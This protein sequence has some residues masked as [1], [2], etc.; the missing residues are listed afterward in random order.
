APEQQPKLDLSASGGE[1]GTAGTTNEDPAP[2]GPS[3]GR[4]AVAPS[5]TAADAW[6]RWLEAGKSVPNG[7]S[8]FLRAAHVR[9]SGGQ[10][11]I[12]L[13]AGPAVERLS[14][15]VVLGQLKEGLAPY[16]GRRPELVIKAPA[17]DA[18]ATSRITEEEVREDTLKALYRKEPRLERAVQELDLELMD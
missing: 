1:Q 7:L 8:A 12:D 14:D 16:L 5:E 6:N 3:G 11:E 17:A 4:D 10:V 15:P 13:P 9:D 2:G 18:N